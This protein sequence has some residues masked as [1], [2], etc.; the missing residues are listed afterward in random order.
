[1]ATILS[2]LYGIEYMHFISMNI[3]LLCINNITKSQKIDIQQIL[4]KLQEYMNILVLTMG[5]LCFFLVHQ[6]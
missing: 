2:V 6:G 3:S 1:M 5:G 4:M